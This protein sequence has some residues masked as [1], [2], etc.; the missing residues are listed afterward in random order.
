MFA[1]FATREAI[2][3]Q[4]IALESRPEPRTCAPG[5]FFHLLAL[6]TH[7]ISV[8]CLSLNGATFLLT[9]VTQ[10]THTQPPK[11]K[12]ETPLTTSATEEGASSHTQTTRRHIGA[13]RDHI[14]H[15][16][17]VFLL[18]MCLRVYCSSKHFKR[19][20]SLGMV[21]MKQL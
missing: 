5:A 9:L 19:C 16:T 8:L 4:L 11:R 2:I 15:G 1:A 12:K 18:C 14:M 6:R 3:L 21:N 10:S 7:D 20:R 13:C 17:C